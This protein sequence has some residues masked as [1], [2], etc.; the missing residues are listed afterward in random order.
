MSERKH[1]IRE[2]AREL[3]QSQGYQATSMQEIADHVGISKGAV[4]LHYRSKEALLL[5][6]I[7]DIDARL[8]GRMTALMD[9]SS[10]S[11]EEKLYAQVLAQ[12]DEMVENRPI[13]EIFLQETGLSLDQELMRF[14]QETRYRWAQLQEAFLVRVYGEALFPWRIDAAVLFNGMM[15]EYHVSM[16]LEQVELPREALGRFLVSVMNSV[17]AGLLAGDHEPILRDESI[18]SRQ[19]M[20]RHL[21]ETAARDL[22]TIVASMTDTVESLDLDADEHAVVTETL[23]VLAD[24]LAAEN[25]NKVLIRGMLASLREVSALETHRQRLAELLGVKLV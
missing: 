11:P 12:L 6:I 19:A 22:S 25:P 16:M 23:A 4:Y 3:F 10:L 15:Q 24:A 20:A 1:Q 5:A 17:V 21:A 13:N 14:L 18:P 7:E 8:V 9:D 2:T